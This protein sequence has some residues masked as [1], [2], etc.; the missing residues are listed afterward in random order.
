MKTLI[1]LCCVLLVVVAA[2]TTGAIQKAGASIRL[3]SSERSVLA[4]VNHA[5]TSRGLRSVRVVASL[6]RAARSHSQ[7]MI[8]RDYFSH[9]SAGGAAFSSRL[10]SFGYSPSGCSSYSVGE[11]IGYSS[12]SSAARGVF[13][14]WMRSSGHRT[15]IL[16]RGFRDVGVG[17]ARGSFCGRGGISMF[18]VDFGRRVR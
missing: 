7:N 4:M 3:T 15:V 10:R 11:I 2:E 17:G 13:G 16:T 6:E 9:C 18:T 12:S 14:A 8:A 5:R 1:L